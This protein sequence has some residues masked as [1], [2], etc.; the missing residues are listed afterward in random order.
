MASQHL[1]KSVRECIANNKR[2]AQYTWTGY[3]CYVPLRDILE[4]ASEE[5]MV[6]LDKM[7]LIFGVDLETVI[8]TYLDEVYL[9]IHLCILPERKSLN[10]RFS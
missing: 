3:V 4:L 8:F 7:L 6:E 10:A 1:I 5:D 9:W 2:C